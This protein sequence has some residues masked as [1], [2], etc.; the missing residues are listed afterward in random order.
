MYEFIGSSFLPYEG[1][2]SISVASVGSYSPEWVLLYKALPVKHQ[3]GS[4]F[5]SFVIQV[6]SPQADSVQFAI[7]IVRKIPSGIK[8]ISTSLKQVS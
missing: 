4:P 6:N 5:W 7:Y 3:E 8:S 1:I 2:W